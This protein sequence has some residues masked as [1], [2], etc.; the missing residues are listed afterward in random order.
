MFKVW[1]VEGM[2]HRPVVLGETHPSV[3]AAF[4][5][6]GKILKGMGAPVLDAQNL[7]SWGGKQGVRVYDPSGTVPMSAVV[8]GGCLVSE[9]T[10]M[11]AGEPLGVVSMADPHPDPQ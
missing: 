11:D 8:E 10:V 3:E 5:S 4:I 1:L 7:P 2:E 6:A 9:G